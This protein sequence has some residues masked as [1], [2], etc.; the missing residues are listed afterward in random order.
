[1]VNHHNW[2]VRYVYLSQG[3]IQEHFLGGELPPKRQKSLHFIRSPY[4]D[5]QLPPRCCVSTLRV[6]KYKISYLYSQQLS[7]SGGLRTPPDPA[8]TAIFQVDWVSWF[9]WRSA[10]GKVT[11]GLTLHYITDIT[12]LMVY[13]PRALTKGD[14]VLHSSGIMSPLPNVTRSTLP[15]VSITTRMPRELTLMNSEASMP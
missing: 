6:R 5:S 12:G 8:L 11:V 9:Q 1:M 4:D 2:R 13:R 15:V 14:Q 3:F 7:D 10:T